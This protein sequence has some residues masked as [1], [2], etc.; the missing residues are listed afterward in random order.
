MHRALIVSLAL[1]ICL[2]ST[3]G[4]A[5]SSSP[6]YGSPSYLTT[7]KPLPKPRAGKRTNFGPARLNCK[8][9]TITAGDLIRCGYD[10]P[11]WALGGNRSRNAPAFRPS[12]F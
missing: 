1:A 10:Y 12:L 4:I 3:A 9:G 7:T 2:P 8:P 11:P 6:G 5:A